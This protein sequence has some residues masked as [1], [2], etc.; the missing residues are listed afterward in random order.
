MTDSKMAPEVPPAPQPQPVIPAIISLADGAGVL[1]QKYVYNTVASESTPIVWSLIDGPE[2]MAVDDLTGA[3]SWNA[4]ELGTHTII[5]RAT[6]EAGFIEQS[7]LLNIVE[8]TPWLVSSPL[9]LAVVGSEYMYAAEARGT[10]PLAWELLQGPSGM[11][12]DSETGEITWA[13]PVEG[14]FY[15]SYSVSNP[16]GSDNWLYTLIVR[17]VPVVVSSLTGTCSVG[18]EYRNV[19]DATGAIPRAWSL[20][21]EPSGMVITPRSGVITWPV[22]VV[23]SYSFVIRIKNEVGGDSYTFSLDVT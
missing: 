4:D 22:P 20:T 6:N 1:G 3:V 13:A 23:G 18:S 14:S 7:Y 5:I 9:R 16:S 21:G 12:I 17:S 8:V 10:A 19:L 2:G 11:V 15:V